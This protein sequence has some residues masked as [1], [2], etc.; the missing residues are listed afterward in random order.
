MTYS[1]KLFD[2]KVEAFGTLLGHALGDVPVYS[3]DYKTAS[4][5][6]YPKRSAYRSYYNG[7]YMGYKW[8][9][10]EFARRWMY[11]N[12]GLIFNDVA[13]AYDIFELRSVRDVTA[14]VE[15]PLNAF[16]NGSQRHP[17][18]GCLLIWKEGGEFEDTGHVAIVT[19]VT[20]EYIRI[21]E[22]N[23]GHALWSE[24]DNYA[25][26]LKA[27]INEDGEYWITCSYGDA[28]ILGWMIQT[29][30]ETFAEPTIDV[31]VEL[32]TLKSRRIHIAESKKRSWLNIANNDEAA[33]VK[34]MGGHFLS[35]VVEEQNRYLILS[36]TTQHALENASNEL[37][38][39]FMHATEYVLSNDELL[40]QFNLPNAILPKIRQSWDNRLNEVITSRFD[41]ALTEDGLK[42]YEYNCDSASCYMETGKVQGKWF[43]HHKLNDDENGGKD[44][45]KDLVKAWKKS[46]V[47][48]VV[49]ILR[50]D[51]PEEEYH[52]LFMQDAIRAAGL[53]S[54]VI[55]GLN[56]LE[57]DEN[58]NII[59]EDGEQVS[60]VWKTWAW[61]TALDQIRQECENLDKQQNVYE[62]DQQKGKS[63]GLSDVLFRKNVM[64]F[65]PLWSLIPS[66]KAILPVL[67]SLFPNHPL[68]LNSSFELSDELKALGYV[69]KPIVGRCGA[70]IS[71][72]SKNEEFVE[73][74]DGH[75]SEQEKIYQQYF[76]LPHVEGSY[77]Q[78][79]TFMVAGVYS[80]SGVRVDRSRVINKNSDCLPLQFV[81]DKQ[82]L[83]E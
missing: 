12:Q 2:K 13:M 39:L 82:F 11:I 81:N 4:D 35:D 71:L 79:S 25:R 34:A 29:E 72:F 20:S 56:G 33:F 1:N 67:W 28:E 30:D 21:A 68:L 75:F 66:N 10:V 78:V 17:S 54:K 58:D 18:I 44:L 37:H 76:P 16:A 24:G 15:L 26:E 42:V 59:D 69:A 57:W 53:N 7:V 73:S 23:V 14:N 41:F 19:E 77:T 50:D 32:N 40:S 38:G 61:E 47:K 55:I 60:W 31:N 51:D 8:Q 48:G 45:F 63:I 27:V 22:Q 62:P 74:T 83:Q 46:H 49:H 52:A 65:E 36:K 43:N 5:I 70:N 64:V 3:S 9:C 80:G 6:D